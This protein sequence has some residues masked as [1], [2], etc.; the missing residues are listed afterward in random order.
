MVG[1]LWILHQESSSLVPVLYCIGTL[2]TPSWMVDDNK[3][4]CV[5]GDDDDD[6]REGRNL[7]CEQVVGRMVVP[8]QGPLPGIVIV[9]A[10]FVLDPVLCPPAC[11]EPKRQTMLVWFGLVWFGCGS[12][13]TQT[14]NHEELQ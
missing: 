14:N 13:T 11:L 1:W 10:D 12:L 2:Y 9:L 8:I 6:K 3:Q 7:G 4:I 5:L